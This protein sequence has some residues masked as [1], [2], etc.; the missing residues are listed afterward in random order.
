MPVAYLLSLII[1]SPTA[2]LSLSIPP[3]TTT[4]KHHKHHSWQSSSS[5]SASDDPLIQAQKQETATKLWNFANLFEWNK[6]HQAEIER[7]QKYPYL[8]C[9]VGEDMSGYQRLLDLQTILSGVGDG[10]GEG[11]NVGNSHYEGGED[12][13]T[14]EYNLDT[15]AAAA[16]SALQ[17][18]TTTSNTSATN[19]N[20]SS[21]SN[22][23]KATSS[24]YNILRPLYNEEDF[25]CVYGQIYASLASNITGSDYI[26][27]PILPAL[28]FMKGS[29]D[30]MQNVIEIVNDKSEEDDENYPSLDIA[31]C[32]GVATVEDSGGV[33]ASISYI[34]ESQ[35]DEEVLD[36]STAQEILE[37]L[38][39]QTSM[40]E[41]LYFTSNIMMYD[42]S[43]ITQDLAANN[44]SSEDEYENERS[45]FWKS[46]IRDYQEKGKCVE[47]YSTRLKWTVERSRSSSI[48]VPPPP[49]LLKV[50]FNTTG[51]TPYDRGCFVLLSLAIA[52][53]PNVCSVESTV[54]VKTHNNV[55]KWLTQS[56]L[57][58][59]R[60]FENVGLNGEGQTVAVTD[61]GLDL[62]NC[63]FVNDSNGNDLKFGSHNIDESQRKVVQYLDFVD[64]SDYAYGHGTHVSGTIAGKRIDGE[65]MADGVAEGAK[66]A[67]GDIGDSNGALSL[68]LDSQLLNTGRPDA[69][70][71]SASWGSELNFYTTQSRNFD[72]FM[73]DN[74]DMLIVVA[75]G[76]SG[77]GDTPNT[78]GSP[79]T[80]KNVIAVGAHHNTDKS[81]PR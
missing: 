19:N 36:E 30:S 26:V 25:L 12:D 8:L 44:E 67:F 75:A 9:H 48:N 7:N 35:Y 56:E 79:A 14:L 59:K 37:E 57:A 20:S 45:Q 43:D 2:H 70:V 11:S 72:Q 16:S 3:Y 17:N 38:S 28:K 66:I 68:P 65:G 32:P 47:T 54:R 63:Y 29:V 81:R 60:P 39:Q 24:P 4:S 76:N 21:N 1:C 53:H 77:H 69:H 61:T 42:T 15:T 71:H 6:A 78:V 62:D 13:L 64:R 73:Y 80:G 50:Q 58:N 34:E 23:T 40:A 46:L 10:E 33:G 22:S 31:L 5:N 55:I 41:S 27:Q 52:T 51:N 74:D 49:P 18:D